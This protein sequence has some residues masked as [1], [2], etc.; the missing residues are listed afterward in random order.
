MTTF[1]LAVG[2]PDVGFPAWLR[3]THLLNFIFMGLLIRSGWEIIST[4]PRMYWRNDCGPGTEWIRFTKKKVPPEEGAYFARDD[5]CSLSPLISLPGRKNV[6]IGR[7]WHAIVTAAWFV[8]G[9]IYVTLLFATGYW[10]RIVPTSWDIFPKAWESLKIYAGFGVPSLEHFQP[11]D[12]LQHLTYFIVV[13]IAAPLM[14]VTGPVMSPAVVGQF[15]WYPKLF[16]GRQAARSLHFL[17]M[18][19]LFTFTLIHIGLV[20]TVH[21]D[22]NLTAMVFGQ[23]DPARA[24]QALTTTIIALVVIVALW[25]GASYW[26]LADLR[27]AQVVLN[28]LGEPLRALTIN[29][30]HSYQRRKQVWTEKDISPYHWS[31]G[32]HPVGDESPEWNALLENDWKDYELEIGGLVDKPIKLSLAQLRAMPRQDQITM[33][34]CMQGWTGIAKWSGVK[35]SDVM[36]LVEKKPNA[37]YLKFTSFGLAQKMHGGK[38]LEPYYS[39]FAPDILDEDETILA[40]DMNDKPLPLTFGAPLR[41]RVEEICGYKMVKYLRKIE[42][43]EDYRKEGDGQGGTREDSGY[44]VINARI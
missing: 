38:P 40:F 13:F 31:N 17:G 2:D 27:R 1:A 35:L 9:V 5:E 18:S 15:P 6:G 10:R 8:N 36:A 41:L 33:H 25:L 29:H 14:I 43:V 39:C 44:Q 34:T 7:H 32:K 37:K 28:K 23:P 30:F 24:A 12:G 11:Y 26:S 4:H 19:F 16:G 3:I 20:F 22:H 21:T 42:W